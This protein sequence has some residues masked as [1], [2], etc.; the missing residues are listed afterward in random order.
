MEGAE[1]R[2]LM[3]ASADEIREQG[4]YTSCTIE[5]EGK[6]TCTRDG[7]DWC[8]GG[9]GVHWGAGGGGGGAA[10]AA[11]GGATASSRPPRPPHA[12]PS[13]PAASANPQGGLRGRLKGRR[14]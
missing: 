4:I 3:Q 7:G 1:G 11:A 9:V 2:E 6:K 8:G 14:L 13:L 12:T 5:I 10:F